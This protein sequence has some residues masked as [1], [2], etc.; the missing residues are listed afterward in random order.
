MDGGALNNVPVEDVR[1]LGADVVIAVKFHA[2]S[3][4]QNSNIMDIVMK[5]VIIF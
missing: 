2:D 1:N 4:D 5:S 3:V